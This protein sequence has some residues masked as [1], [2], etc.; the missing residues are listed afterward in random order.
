MKQWQLCAM[1]SFTLIGVEDDAYKSLEQNV[2]SLAKKKEIKYKI[3]YV[4]RVEDIM[5]MKIDS[6][7]SLH[8]HPGDILLSNPSYNAIES[9]MTIE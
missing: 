6:I 7:P 4:N 5:Q 9:I 8:I 1:I 2:I 3:S